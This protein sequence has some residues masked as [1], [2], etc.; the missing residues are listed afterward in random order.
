MAQS[1]SRNVWKAFAAMG[2]LRA[3]KTSWT[4]TAREARHLQALG[5]RVGFI[6][7]GTKFS[8][9]PFSAQTAILAPARIS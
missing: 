5:D 9:V 6:V 8:A 4:S 7:A 3:I 1:M 2:M